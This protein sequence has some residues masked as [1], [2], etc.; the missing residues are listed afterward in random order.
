MTQPQ[1][2]DYVKAARPPAAKALLRRLLLQPQVN[3][4]AVAVLKAMPG[5]AWRSRVPVVGAA[6]LRV[7]DAEPVVLLR[8]DRCQVARE[9]FW[10][11]GELATAAERLALDLAV[12][13]ATQAEL[14]IDIGAYTGLFALAVARRNPQLVA[15]A[16]EIVG[17][18]FLVMWEN[19]ICN[20]LVG[21]V[22][23]CLVALGAERG[24]LHVP[25]SVGDGALASS[26][27]LDSAGTSGTRIP[28][29]TLDGRYESFAG[30]AVIK[31]DVE[32]FEWDVLRGG[33]RFL[34]RNRPDMVCEVL[35]RARHVAE[36]EAF[37]RPM[38]YRIYHISDAGLREAAQVVAVKLE[39]DW[40][41]STR[42]P[43]ELRELGFP[44]AGA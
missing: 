34:E 40:L 13:L 2:T 31:I 32:G 30:R 3:R 41:F 16:Y 44:I 21:R 38:G 28:V 15:H 14:F 6:Q 23:P 33:R 12:R 17:E 24:D 27:A 1:G 18:N 36:M 19:V 43:Q 10:A 9:V 29:D 37:L 25:A 7:Q 39:R 4:L 35:R 20:D 11:G 22:E 26:V 8:G 5:F 42:T